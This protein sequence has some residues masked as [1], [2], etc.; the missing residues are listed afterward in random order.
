MKPLLFYRIKDILHNTGADWDKLAPNIEDAINFA[1]KNINPEP[2]RQ[3][4]N[5][6]FSLEYCL[7]HSGES[8]NERLRN[9]Q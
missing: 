4:D 3:Y 8:L 7:A 9:D 6:K 2:I 1:H 5:F